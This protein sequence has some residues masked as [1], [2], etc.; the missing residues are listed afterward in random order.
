MLAARA[1]RP[2]GVDADVFGLYFDVDVLCLRQNRD[3]CS[4]GVDA[5]LVLGFR[6]ALHAMHAGLEL[7][8]R[9]N[10][11]AADARHDF[12]VSARIRVA[13]R[14]NLHFPALQVGI[15]L[16]HA[17]KIRR[18]QCRLLAARACANLKN[19]AFFVR[20][21]LRQ[22]HDLQFMLELLDPRRQRLPV[23]RGRVRAMSGSE[24]GSSVIWRRLSRSCCAL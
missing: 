18:E 23:P 14:K 1:A 22:K 8:S 12:L 16:I 11:L 20:R 6:H 24:A 17:E 2:H 15:A 9:E 4:R 5:A 21:I 19:G 3:G 13:G 7:H 10:A